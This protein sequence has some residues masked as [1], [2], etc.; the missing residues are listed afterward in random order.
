MPR[1]RVALTVAL[2]ATCSLALFSQESPRWQ[3]VLEIGTAQ[4]EA[5]DLAQAERTYQTALTEAETAGEPLG[6]SIV[7]DTLGE[8]Y[9]RQKRI[10]DVEALHRRILAWWSASSPRSSIMSLIA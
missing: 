9:R 1:S 5:G 3:V 4:L 2:I 6:L 8:L 7:A 10:D